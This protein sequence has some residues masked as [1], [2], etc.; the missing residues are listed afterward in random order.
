MNTLVLQWFFC[1]S[2]GV[3]LCFYKQF[4]SGYSELK[5]VSLSA[6][7]GQKRSWTTLIWNLLFFCKHFPFLCCLSSE[8][9]WLS[10]TD[11]PDNKAKWDS[12]KRG[13]QEIAGSLPW[14]HFKDWPALCSG[15]QGLR[16]SSLCSSDDK[17]VQKL[18]FPGCSTVQQPPFN[19]QSNCTHG[20][21]RLI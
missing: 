9:K 17:L 11:N 3:K 4:E 18:L 5:W 12:S 21:S 13:T 2:K 6:D 7:H 14:H 16:G 1:Y 8:E 10:V 15:H 19:F 20:Q